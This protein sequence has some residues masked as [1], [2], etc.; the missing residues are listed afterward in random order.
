MGGP[1]WLTGKGFVGFNDI[2]QDGGSIAVGGRTDLRKEINDI[3]FTASI[4]DASARDYEAA[5]WLKDSIITAEKRLND[6]S[7][8]GLGYDFGA[9]NAFVSVAGETTVNNKPLTA[10]GTW[11]QKGNSIRTEADVQIDSRQKLWGTY[12]FNT[13]ANEV[14]S[15]YV[16]LKERQGFIIAP[17]T[18]PTATAAATYTI[19]KD[20]YVIE[21]QYN[22][23]TSSAYL[24]VGRNKFWRKN[25]VKAH[26]AF[27]EQVAMVDFTYNENKSNDKPL[28]KA[29]IK[30][31]AGQQGFGPLSV[32]F[33][34]DKTIDV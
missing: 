15:T 20:G 29:Y 1:G 11:F 21:P 10:R 22:F 26:Y 5:P 33:I 14:N 16:N 31:N 32:G 34:V 18:L 4:T 12:T 24:S 8:V 30:A 28:A 19:E 6:Q 17:F 27:N 23:H 25:H 9:Q 3:K 2:G 7:S 13:P